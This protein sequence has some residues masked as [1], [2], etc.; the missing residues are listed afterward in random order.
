MSNLEHL[1]ENA[2]CDME[3]GRSYEEY[4]GEWAQQAMLPMVNVKPEELWEIAQYVITTYRDS[5][6]YGENSI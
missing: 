6:L 2:I 4:V 3:R 1:I 5:V